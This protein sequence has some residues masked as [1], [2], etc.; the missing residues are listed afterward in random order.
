MGP[1]DDAKPSQ[2]GKGFAL[3]NKF[4]LTIEHEC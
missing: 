2:F 1:L 4:F 3:G